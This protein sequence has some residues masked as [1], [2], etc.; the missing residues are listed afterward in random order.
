MIPFQHAYKLYCLLISRIYYGL[1][2]KIKSTLKPMLKRTLKR[3]TPYLIGGTITGIIMSYY[4]GFIVSIVVNS[5]IWFV[6]STIVNKYYWNYTG[7]KE[8]MY[9]VKFGLSR[10]NAR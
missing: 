10:I 1:Y 5:A 4:Y 2:F 3:Q 7:F 8:E 9:L 6:I